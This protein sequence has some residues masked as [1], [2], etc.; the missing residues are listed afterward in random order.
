MSGEAFYRSMDCPNCGRHRVHGPAMGKEDGVC[1]K[2]HWDVDAGKY[3]TISRPENYT[4]D[5]DYDWLFD[6]TSHAS[7]RAKPVHK[8]N[9]DFGGVS[10]E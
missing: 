7:D 6:S 4:P 2:C 5:D 10:D 3:A 8:P 9:D 1:E